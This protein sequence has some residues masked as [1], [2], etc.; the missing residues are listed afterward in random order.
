M[1]HH[2]RPT[3]RDGQQN[4]TPAANDEPLL[5]AVRNG[6]NQAFGELYERHR[7]A[8][9]A[10]ARLHTHSQ[11]EAEDITSEAFT[12]VLALLKSGGGPR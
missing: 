1:E 9:F 2:R 10:V 12:R 4:S 3:P 11:A 7:G 6:D 8:V 5:D